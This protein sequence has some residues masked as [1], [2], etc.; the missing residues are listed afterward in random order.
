MTAVYAVVARAAT[1]ETGWPCS[2]SIGSRLLAE[3]R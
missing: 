1:I 3:L 2:F